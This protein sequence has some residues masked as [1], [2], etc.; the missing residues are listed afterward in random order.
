MNQ[1]FSEVYREGRNIATKNKF[2]GNT[3]YGE[4]IISEKGNEFRFWNPERSKLAAA[5]QNGL[6]NW[7][8][9]K[10][11]NVLYLGASSGTTPS[12]VA[13]IAN[14]VFAVEI[15]KRMMRDL[16]QISEVRTNVIPILADA[17]KPETYMDRILS[18]DFIYQDVAQPNQ[19]EILNKNAEIFKPKFAMLAIK[20]RSIDVTKNPSQIFKKEIGKLN[21]F[22]VIEIIKLYPYDKDHVLVNLGYNG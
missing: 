8:L 5:I 10:D 4:K 21:N 11:H 12:H 3:V 22:E 6:R 17:S 1:I 14:M 9:K 19:A 18:V 2:K 20:A 16:I 15:S 7:T 13:D